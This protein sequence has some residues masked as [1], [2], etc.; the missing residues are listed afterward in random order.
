VADGAA[1][2]WLE[3][4]SSG[5]D[6]LAWTA[7]LALRE[8]RQREQRGRQAPESALDPWAGGFGFPPGADPFGHQQRMQGLLDALLGVG[9]EGLH[10]VPPVSGGVGPGQGSSESFSLQLGP[11]GVE[12]RVFKNVD[13]RQEERRYEAPDLPTLLRENPELESILGAPGGSGAFGA[14]PTWPTLRSIPRG[15][16]RSGVPV[17]QAN[18]Q[19]PRTDQLGV[20]VAPVAAGP[21]GEGGLLVHDTVPGSI[22]H[23]LGLA[24]G[25][26]LL[27]VNDVPLR[28]VEDLSR[29]LAERP[30]QGEIRARWRA[31]SGREVERVW[32]PSAPRRSA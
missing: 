31:P 29:V 21:A 6:E 24:R 32:R 15:G 10:A 13:G 2:A 22:A 14:T 26:V 4:R 1:R 30:E 7:R 25:D 18:D 27:A 8:L 11:D 5:A 23:V 3:E 17:P 20:L 28:Q 12:V 19:G 16:V 9:P